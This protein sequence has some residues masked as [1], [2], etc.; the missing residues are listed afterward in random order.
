MI[1]LIWWAVLGLLFFLVGATLLVLVYDC[2]ACMTGRRAHFIG[3]ALVVASGPLVWIW[4]GL[5]TLLDVHGRRG[6]R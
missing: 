5:D 2:W 6:L 4:V 1:Y 3:W